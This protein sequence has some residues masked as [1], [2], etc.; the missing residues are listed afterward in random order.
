MWEEEEEIQGP[1]NHLEISYP[2][3]PT[4]EDPSSMPSFLQRHTRGPIPS[5][6]GEGSFHWPCRQ[7]SPIRNHNYHECE[8]SRSWFQIHC[9]V[10]T[11]QGP[12]SDFMVNTN[13]PTEWL[14][15]AVGWGGGYKSSLKLANCC[16]DW[17]DR[18]CLHLLFVSSYKWFSPGLS[19]ILGGSKAQVSQDLVSTRRSWHRASLRVSSASTGQ[20]VD[21]R[22]MSY[23]G[24]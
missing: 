14:L 20:C 7:K 12:D 24:I 18:H 2:P 13:Q 9:P 15:V 6:R 16:A 5:A 11:D 19:H 17:G 1:V 3:T 21:F 22:Q 10:G 23:L 4:P 8:G